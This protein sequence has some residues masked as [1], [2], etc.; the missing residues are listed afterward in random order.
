MARVFSVNN[1]KII[2]IGSNYINGAIYLRN[3]INDFVVDNL[4]ITAGVNFTI[5][6]APSAVTTTIKNC[7]L[8]GLYAT[9]DSATL[10]NCTVNTIYASFNNG[11]N[12]FF[13]FIGCNINQAVGAAPTRAFANTSVA[14]ASRFVFK[15]CRIKLD[16]IYGLWASRF[17]G[18]DIDSKCFVSN[19]T[20]YNPSGRGFT[21]VG[22]ITY[23]EV[24]NS[25]IG[26]ASADIVGGTGINSTL[27]LNNI[28]I[29]NT[30]LGT[31]I[32]TSSFNNVVQDSTPIFDLELN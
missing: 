26:T 17:N 19:C 31:L 6:V 28:L 25:K 30:L 8:N 32:G 1:V 10:S 11:F 20:I 15:D 22:G 21:F 29:N 12:E 16:C 23:L 9:S 5:C 14:N 24:I 2:G 27:V 7:I 4:N 13:K 3:A 18:S